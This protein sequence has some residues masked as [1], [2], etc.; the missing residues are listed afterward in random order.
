MTRRPLIHWLIIIAAALL[1]LA[2]CG[3]SRLP[4]EW[5]TALAVWGAEIAL[6]LV[7][8][9]QRFAPAGLARLAPA[10]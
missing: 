2:S 9:R 10:L 1:A 3:C 7:V 5:R 8:I 6:V 4:M